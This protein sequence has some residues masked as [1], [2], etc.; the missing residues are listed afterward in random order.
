MSQFS[1][2]YLEKTNHGTMK[3]IK[4]GMLI[5]CAAIIELYPNS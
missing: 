4:L 3:I 1:P 2:H 5:S